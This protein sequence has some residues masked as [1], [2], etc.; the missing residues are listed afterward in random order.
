MIFRN[1]TVAEKGDVLALYESVKGQPFC[2]WDDTYPTIREIEHDMETD[3]LFVLCEDGRVIGALS[4]M[5]ENEMDGLLSWRVGGRP[6]EIARIA[7][8]L[9]CRGR[10]LAGYMVERICGILRERGCTAVRISAATKNTPALKTYARLG[11]ETVGQEEMY[12]GS[13]YLLEKAI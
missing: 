13:Y 9:D 7:V 6:Q 8:S 3:N 12:G 5:P 4:V 11:F 2:A 10:G 1:A